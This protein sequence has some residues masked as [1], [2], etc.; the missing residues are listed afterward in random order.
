LLDPCPS[1]ERIVAALAVGCAAAWGV[2]MLAGEP[3]AEELS[4]ASELVRAR[5]GSERWNRTGCGFVPVDGSPF[6]ARRD[7]C[8][9]CHSR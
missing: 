9:A 2:R 4:A 8:D 6:D 3:T 1:L 7:S 5:Y